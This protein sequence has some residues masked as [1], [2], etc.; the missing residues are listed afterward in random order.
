LRDPDVLLPLLT[1]KEPWPW[2]KIHD[3]VLEGIDYWPR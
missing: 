2:L 1:G 3:V